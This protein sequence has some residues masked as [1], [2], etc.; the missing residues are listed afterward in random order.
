MEA[1]KQHLGPDCQSALTSDVAEDIRNVFCECSECPKHSVQVS[2]PE[3]TVVCTVQP[4]FVGQ[5]H[6]PKQLQHTQHAQN[7]SQRNLLQAWQWLKWTSTAF[8]WTTSDGV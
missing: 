6:V 7:P 8:G 4:R 2:E 5:R 1:C 3:V